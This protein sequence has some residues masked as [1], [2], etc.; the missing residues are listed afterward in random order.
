MIANIKKLK[1]LAMDLD[2]TDEA[3]LTE[4]INE[5][6]DE[7]TSPNSIIEWFNSPFISEFD[8][9]KALSEIMKLNIKL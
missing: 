1:N 8:K 5:L 9:K 2:F 7:I 3:N 4:A 6:E